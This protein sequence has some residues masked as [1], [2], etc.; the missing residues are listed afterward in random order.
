MASEICCKLGY[1]YLDF[2]PS[3]PSKIMYELK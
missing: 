2:C 3:S 1:F